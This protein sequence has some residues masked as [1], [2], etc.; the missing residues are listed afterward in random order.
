MSHQDLNLRA[1]LLESQCRVFERIASRA[2]LEEVLEALVCLIEEQAGGMRCAIL[3]A[4]IGAQRLRFVAA[5]NIPEDYKVGIAPY[6]LI[7]PGATSCGIAAHRREP[8]YTEDTAADP[9]WENYREIAVRNGLRAV[10]STPILSDVGAILGTFAMYYDVPRLPAAEHIQIIDM[11]THL[12]RVAIDAKR[13][14]QILRTVLEGAPGGV[15]I[16]DLT[17]KISRVNHAFADMLGYTPRELHD[18]TIADITEDAD[19]APLVAKLLS[20]GHAEM[21]SNRRYRTKSRTLVRALER[22]VLSPDVSGEPRFVI[23]HVHRV[24]EARSDPL[25]PLSRREREVL[26]RVIAGRTSKQIAAQLG[27]APASVDTYRSRIMVKLGI[28]D[29]PGLVRFAMQHDIF[30]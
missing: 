27:I 10:W 19:Q 7:A 15:L 18:R 12:A 3:L 22:Y 16:T 8:V 23:T 13:G 2:P 21:L 28:R 14:D 30:S 1:A 25:E 20:N 24:I 17:G 9:L 6:L 29:L 26:Q 11:A 5:P 4:D